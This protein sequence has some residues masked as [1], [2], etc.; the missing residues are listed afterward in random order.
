M[1]IVNFNVSDPGYATSFTETIAIDDGT[2][3]TNVT[4]TGSV[5]NGGTYSP[6][7][8]Y[9]LASDGDFSAGYAHLDYTNTIVLDFE[10]PVSNFSFSIGDLDQGAGWDDQVT[11]SAIDALG[12]PVTIV[13]SGN[14]HH[15]ITTSGETVTIE[16]EADSSSGTGGALGTLADDVNVNIAGPLSQVTITFQ[17]G[18]DSD[19]SGYIDFGNF[20]ADPAPICFALG[21]MIRTPDGER[22]IEDLRAGDVVVTQ[23][24]GP[25]KIAWIGGRKLDAIDLRVNTKFRPIV[26][27]ADSLG[28]GFPK[29][30]LVVSPQ[31]RILVR[32][33]IAKRMFGEDEVLVAATRLVGLPGIYVAEEIEEV[34]YFHFLFD[35][36][37]IV[38]AEAVASESLFTGPETLKAV[39][40][41]A[42]EEILSLFPELEDEEYSLSPARMIPSGKKQKQLVARHFKNGKT[43]VSM[44]GL[45]PVS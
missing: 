29:R 45:P 39:T 22:A 20:A 10:D 8:T 40:R 24:H 23:D 14:T 18:P 44:T 43:V 42:R 41:A 27:S 4:I 33:R 32:S 2:N 30:D 21:T 11:I 13:I 37:E 7:F 15:T 31:H 9:A 34:E 28:H 6:Y 17:D 16:G 1:S 26:L 25:K 19:Y 36:H 3:S 38:F 12:N 5:T 35:Q